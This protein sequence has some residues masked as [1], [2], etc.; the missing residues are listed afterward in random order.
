MLKKL[1]SKITGAAGNTVKP[2]DSAGSKGLLGTIAGL[3][4]AK[5]VAKFFPESAPDF[6]SA[7]EYVLYGIGTLFLTRKQK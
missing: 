1:I 5:L 4:A 7:L 3:L 2:T 6:V